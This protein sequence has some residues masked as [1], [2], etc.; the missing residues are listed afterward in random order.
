MTYSLKSIRY[1][2]S[3]RRILLQNENGPCPLLAA[4]NALLLKG[5][6]ELPS[7]CVRNSVASLEDVANV[8]A[9]RAMQNHQTEAHF[10][11]EL[12]HHIPKLQYGMDV[13]PKFTD[14]CTGYEYTS[15]L[16]AFDMLRVRLV[17]GWLADPEHDE[18]YTAVGNK[19]YNELVEWIIKGN[20]AG[21][22]VEKLQKE[23]D[24]LQVRQASLVAKEVSD[25]SPQGTVE[26]AIVQED[27]VKIQAKYDELS[28]L[29]TQGS[30][31]QNF[32]EATSHQLTQYGLHVLHEQIHEDEL[33]VFFRNNHYG[34]L[35]KRNGMLYI[36]VTDLGYCNAPAIVWEMLDVID[37]DT[38][39]ADSDFKPPG[40]K[41]HL[42]SGPTLS[43]EQLLAQASQND[44]DYNLAVQL[45]KG[46]NG[47]ISLDAQEGDL[48]AAATQASLRDYHGMGSGTTSDEPTDPQLPKYQRVELGVPVGRMQT[49][50]VDQT[51][52]QTSQLAALSSNDASLSQV[53]ADHLLAMQLEVGPDTVRQNDDPSVHLARQLQEEENQLAR[54]RQHQ[55]TTTHA[56]S[57]VPV[58]A[59]SPASRSNCLIS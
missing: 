3:D 43:P 17:H 38:E 31:M 49:P 21:T 2:G 35:T 52:G 42:T 6:I 11:D 48:M 45:S 15:E 29:A 51:P 18:T 40:A 30:L 32:L 41:A 44:A 20:E 9:N 27:M 26:A 47:S 33:V 10:V 28:E 16:T 54:Q 58:G 34:T 14:G 13:N 23:M 55:T 36:L 59:T 57:R 5:V 1:Q 56:S 8:L 37:G 12:M 39:Y 22:E 7:R 4:A 25:E 53:D 50:A 24:L 46:D 19:T